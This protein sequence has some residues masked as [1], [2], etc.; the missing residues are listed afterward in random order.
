M[1]FTKL[2]LENALAIRP[3]NWEAAS[4]PLL[5]KVAHCIPVPP[6]RYIGKCARVLKRS[7]ST[8][9]VISMTLCFL[10]SRVT[11]SLFHKFTSPTQGNE[12]NSII[13]VLSIFVNEHCAQYRGNQLQFRGRQ[14][15]LISNLKIESA[16]RFSLGL[17]CNFF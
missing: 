3:S 16:P 15:I 6:L 11:V 2:L 8:Q 9:I 17:L 13:N 7:V 1:V 10:R 12:E 4:E 14:K 5:P